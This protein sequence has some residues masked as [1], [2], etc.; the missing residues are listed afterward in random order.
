MINIYNYILFIENISSKENVEINFDIS[1]YDYKMVNFKP[2]VKQLFAIY[3]F[4][5]QIQKLFFLILNKVKVIIKV[6]Y[7]KIKA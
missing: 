6:I 1:L 3:I 5:S 7:K 2:D 4:R